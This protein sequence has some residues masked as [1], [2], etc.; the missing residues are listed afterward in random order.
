MEPDLVLCS[1]A[2]RTRETLERIAPTLGRA[3]VRVEEE[4]YV[5][6]GRTLAARVSLLDAGIGT[7]MLIAH[8]PGIQDLALSLAAEGTE[9]DRLERKF[10]T[11]ALATLA[12]EGEWRGLA[13]GGAQLVEFV[14]PRDLG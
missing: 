3:E 12:F 6:S 5:A 7:A 1:S 13:P 2:V 9:R 11:A 8:N 10:P 14:R 4:L